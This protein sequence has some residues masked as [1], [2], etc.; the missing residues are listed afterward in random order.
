MRDHPPSGQYADRNLLF[1]VLALQMDFV[2][3]EALVAAMN[4]WVLAKHRPIGEILVE[5]NS[6][7][8]GLQN[9]LEALV[10]AHIQRHNGDPLRSLAAVGVPSTVQRGLESIPDRDLHAT[11]SA[12]GTPSRAT[13]DLSSPRTEPGMRYEV[14]RPHARGGLGVVSVARDA[15]LG[16]EVALKEMQ[17]DYAEQPVIRERFLREAE[18]TGGLEHPG[19]VPVYGLGRRADGRP[20]YAMRL[21][22]GETLLEAANKLARGEPGYTLRGLLTR[23]VAVC[24]AVAYAHSRGVIHRDLKPANVLLG[25]YGETLVV[26]WGLAKVVGRPAEPGPGDRV[27]EERTLLVTGNNDGSKTRAGT[28]MGTPAYMSPEQAD[29][30]P[31]EQGPATDVYGLG[32]TLYAVLTGRGP[33]EGG[34]TSAALERVRQGTWAAPR[35]VKPS[36]PKPLDAICRKAMALRPADRYPSALAL[37]ADVDH[38]LA[39]EP[40]STYRETASQRL[41]RW[42]KRHK[43]L[44]AGATALLLSAVVALAAGIVAVSREKQRTDVAL[45]QA[46]HETGRA[47]EA[48]SRESQARQLTREAL[49]EM[50]SQVIEDWLSRRGPLEPAQRTF[51]NKALA[52]YETFAAESGQSEEVRASVMEA[53]ERI[54]RIRYRLGQ[55]AEAEAADRRALDLA[56]SLA[57]E[58]PATPQYRQKLARIHHNLGTVLRETGRTQEAEAAYRNSLDLRRTLQRAF[59]D[60]RVYRHEVAMACNSLGSLLNEGRPAEAEPVYRDALAILKPLVAEFPAVPDYTRALAGTDYGL[61]ESLRKT[62]RGKEAEVGYQDALALLKPLA[63]ALHTDPEYRVEMART[64]NSLGVLFWENERGEAAEAFY[65]D[66]LATRNSLATDF[67]AVPDYRRG[68]ADS[69]NN[70]ANL[71]QN[72]GKAKEAEAAY[73]S[74]LAIMQALATDFPTVPAYR[75]RVGTTHGNLAEL[76]KG[77][78]RLKEAEAAYRDAVTVLRA[79]AVEFPADAEYSALLANVQDGSAELALGRKEYSAARALLG[80]ALTNVKKALGANAKSPFYRAVYCENRR[81]LATTL[82]DAGDHRGAA[83]AAAELV[84]GTKQP[85][86]DAYKAACFFSR[87]IPLAEEDPRLSDSRRRE[88]TLSYGDQ[89]LAAL[90]QARAKGYKDIDHLKKDADLDPLRQREDFKNLLAQVE[91]GKAAAEKK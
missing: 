35:E 24:N 9:Q 6:L 32:A 15:E 36:T 66:A 44:L 29:G 70:L 48:L 86:S 56:G 45:E 39:D 42:G 7:P 63:A 55:H 3:R 57:A 64:Q 38:W 76:L 13:V 12:A 26:D 25:P 49:D 16:R 67:P 40:V 33:I 43:P 61:G 87:C 14:L 31:D 22:R 28:V 52:Y 65:R 8:A 1:G 23:F 30:R 88:L 27:V 11:I 21:I 5:Q 72:M 19:V 91:A 20:Y 4:A 78:G 37:A 41:W 10:D 58:F 77:M 83:E 68:L 46:R 81:L 17:G 75:D 79:L 62:G 53:H 85:V 54:G 60:E 74:N 89:A 84:R 82:V 34:E 69:Y 18:I 59:P 90:E 71:L 47:E 2:S 51:L 73:R 50:S 80:E